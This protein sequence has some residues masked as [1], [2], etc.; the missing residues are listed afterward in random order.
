MTWMST[1]YIKAGIELD[2]IAV[3]GITATGYHG[4]FEEEKREGQTFVAD[5]VAH[6]STRKAAAADALELTINYAQIAQ[7]VYDVLAGEPFD[8]IETVAERCALA[9]LDMDGVHCVDVRIHK[10]QAPIPVPFADASVTIRRDIRTGGLWADKRVGSSAGDPQDP[11]DF[12]PSVRA[13]DALDHRPLQP[14]PA[15][16]AF[17]GNLGDAELTLREAVAQIGR[18]PGIHVKSTSK[19]VKTPPAGGPPQPDYL[20]AVVRIETM[21]SPR[22]VLAACH[23]IEMVHGRERIVRNGPR[24][25]DIDLIDYDGMSASAAD[26]AVP[27]PRAKDR[28][29]VLVPWWWM[30]PDAVL[31][32]IGAIAPLAVHLSPEVTVVADPW[33]APQLPSNQASS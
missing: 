19:L 2:R 1:P 7:R 25:L 29:F 27:H 22:E 21:L 3:E 15:L 28:S 31:A 11:L 30:E 8:L 5:V 23:G 32:G 33:P 9:V 26:L 17:G 18:I 6:A 24:T 12:S 16:L 10:P 13:K 4:V 20:N 14:I